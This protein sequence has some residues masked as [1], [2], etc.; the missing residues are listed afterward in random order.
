MP[1]LGVVIGYSM[2][3][4]IILNEGAWASD[5]DHYWYQSFR[6]QCFISWGSALILFFIP[7]KFININEAVAMKREFLDK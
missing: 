6:L 7:S 4:A 5:Y 1:P 2:T 3:S